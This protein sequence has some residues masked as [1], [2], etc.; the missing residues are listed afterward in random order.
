MR[1]ALPAAVG[2]LV[3]VASTGCATNNSAIEEEL[4]RLRRE[5]RSLNEKIS[6]SDLK[7]ERLEG[8]VTLLALGQS[9]EVAP[10]PKTP[11]VGASEPE[12]K[13]KVEQPKISQLTGPQRSLPVVKLGSEEDVRYDEG[14]VADGSPPTLIKVTGPEEDELAVD[15][16]V[17]TKPEP[18]PDGPATPIRSTNSA[19]NA[20]Y[21]IA[22]AKVRTEADPAAARRLLQ[23]FAKRYP[24]S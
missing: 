14:A 4:S 9:G 19:V 20:A 3:L 16:P 2:L 12:T 8:R 17:L 23:Q 5:V 6:E 13:K 21:E 18:V 15:P 7:L 24:A 1:G 22:V 10:A 11:A